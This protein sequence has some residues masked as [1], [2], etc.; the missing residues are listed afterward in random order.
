LLAGALVGLMLAGTAGAQQVKISASGTLTRS[1]LG[2]NALNLMIVNTGDAL[3]GFGLQLKSGYTITQMAVNGTPCQAGPTGAFCKQSLDT[4]STTAATLTTDKQYPDGA[5][6]YLILQGAAGSTGTAPVTG[7]G[8]STPSGPCKC[9]GLT[10]RILPSSIKFTNPGESAGMHLEFTVFWT[11]SCL[12]GSGGCQGTLDFVAP[13][14]KTY[15]SAFKKPGA[16]I[17]CT[18]QCAQVTTGTQQL[19]LIGNRGLGGDRRGK[20]VPSIPIRIKRTCQGAAVRPLML[21]LV[22]DKKTALVD[23]QKSKLR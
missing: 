6:G 7:P 3:T 8:A 14:G 11:L 16:H 17:V 21:S 15:K 9:L 4:G 19:I 2:P 13:Q 23:K 1:S 18:G 22:F 20:T 5:G 12:T 10:A